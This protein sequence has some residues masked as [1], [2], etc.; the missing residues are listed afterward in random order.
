MTAADPSYSR[1]WLIL[2]VV[3]VAR[4]MVVLDT[5]V[6]NTALPSAQRALGTGLGPSPTQTEDLA[7]ERVAGNHHHP[8][9][10]AHL[11]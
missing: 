2:A 7:T 11:G 10:T 5:T 6:L 1:R 8:V 9:R 3:G 4:V